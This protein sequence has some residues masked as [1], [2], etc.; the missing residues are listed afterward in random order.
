MKQP[1]CALADVPHSG[2]R[3]VDFFGREALVYRQGGGVEAERSMRI[4]LRDLLELMDGELV[5]PWHGARFGAA[6]GACRRANEAT[7]SKAMFLPT[8]V[9]D[10]MLTYV[11]GQ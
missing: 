8:R 11:W 4:L 2:I 7:E 3:K 10:G 5:C 6:S 9:K 1:L